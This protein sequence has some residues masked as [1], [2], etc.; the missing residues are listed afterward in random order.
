MDC[1][2]IVETLRAE[3]ISFQGKAVEFLK[4]ELGFTR[5]IELYLRQKEA[6]GAWKKAGRSAL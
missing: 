3:K 1:R 4:L 6:L 2:E 5:E